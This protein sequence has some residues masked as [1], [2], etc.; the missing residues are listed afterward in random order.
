MG[1]NRYTGYET[2]DR[3]VENPAVVPFGGVIRVYDLSPA[4]RPLSPALGGLQNVRVDR[5]CRQSGALFAGLTFEVFGK[6]LRL[7]F[8][9]TFPERTKHVVRTCETANAQ[10][11]RRRE[12][13]HDS[14]R[15]CDFRHK[16]YASK[17]V[18]I[19]HTA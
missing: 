19:L 9:D 15:S 8:V 17:T 2:Y 11:T 14:V 1:F 10:N 3:T 5:F 7:N 13:L 16:T 4:N 12:L 18:R 6:R